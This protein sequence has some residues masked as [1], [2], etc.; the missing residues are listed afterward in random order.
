MSISRRHIMSTMAGVAFLPGCAAIDLVTT[1]TPP[2]LFELTPKTTFDV[3]PETDA[4]IIIEPATAA[5]GLNTAR[6][7]LRPEPTLLEYYANALWVDVVP[8]MVQTLLVETLDSTGSIQAMSPAEAAGTRPEFLL[9][10]NIREFQAEYAE[11]IDRPPT[12]NLRLQ[13]RLLRLPRRLEVDE[14]DEAASIVAT[15]TA[16]EEV[17]LAYDEALGKVLKRLGTW[18]IES[19]KLAQAAD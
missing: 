12:V 16:I 14:L 19:V 13:A 17:V 10:L 1:R 6:I 11:G 3:L 5:A 7:A 9:R 15:G 18:V 4:V 2:K 8:V